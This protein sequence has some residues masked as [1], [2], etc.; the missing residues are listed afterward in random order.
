M[1]PYSCR[2]TLIIIT[3]ALGKGCFGVHALPALVNAEAHARAH[4]RTHARTHTHIQRGV[5]LWV[6]ALTLTF[7]K[8]LIPLSSFKCPNVTDSGRTASLSF[9]H[10][11]THSQTPNKCLNNFTQMIKQQTQPRGISYN[12]GHTAVSSCA[13]KEARTTTL[14]PSDRHPPVGHSSMFTL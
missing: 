4:T 12:N 10:T 13:V 3:R 9:T 5:Q 8:T 7:N 14:T 11:Y 2:A 1:K 6:P